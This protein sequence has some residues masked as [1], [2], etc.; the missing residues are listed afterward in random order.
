VARGSAC[1]RTRGG[2]ILVTVGMLAFCANFPIRVSAQDAREKYQ[3]QYQA[4]TDPVR[5]AKILGKLGSLEVRQARADL[6]AGED[7]KSLGV[8]EHYRDEVRATVEALSA[9]GVNAER[10]PA[11]FKELQIGL[12]QTVRQLDDLI[13]AATFDKRESFQAVRSDL[14]GLQNS[15]INAL[16]PDRDKGKKG[17]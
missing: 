2:A 17:D 16:F 15:L 11:G 6:R 10:H 3:A 8:L 7:D 4:E 5:K 14:I 12:R 13:A 9:T 1:C